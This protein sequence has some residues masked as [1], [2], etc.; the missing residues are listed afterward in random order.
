MNN[1]LEELGATGVI[2]VFFIIAL[3]IIIKNW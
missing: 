3:A 2:V 1:K